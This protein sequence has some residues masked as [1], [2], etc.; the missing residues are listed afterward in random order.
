MI[1]LLIFRVIYYRCVSSVGGRCHDTFFCI[2]I[3]N[4]DGSIVS[5]YRFVEES[6]KPECS[7]V[8]V[9]RTEPEP[10]RKMLNNLFEGQSIDVSE[11]I[12]EELEE[13]TVVLVEDGRVVSQSPLAEISDSIL[14][15]NSDLYSTGTVGLEETTVPAVI[16]GL[17][18]SQFRL[19][20]YPESNS[21]KLL[22]IL[23]SRHIE[24]VAYNTGEGT[25]RSSFQKLSRIV[26]ERGT[27]EVYEQI[28]D[29]PV[30]VHVYGQPDW[31]PT[32][33]FQVTAHSASSGG[34]SGLLVRRLHTSRGGT[35]RTC[36]AG[37][38]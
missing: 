8:L 5:L 29:S 22:L 14:M 32:P 24:R 16:D 3:E 15:V 25:L 31:M 20:G 21:E 33:E 9:N 19:R 23:I 36:G 12:D 30:D 38:D 17:A 27:R 18:G 10:F 26:D 35:G 37:R 28:A 13:N 7:L 6:E 1:I 4:P 11:G 34:L 2:G